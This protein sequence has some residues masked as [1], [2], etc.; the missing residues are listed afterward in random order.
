MLSGIESRLF[1]VEREWV[2]CGTPPVTLAPSAL[3]AAVVI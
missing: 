2:I 3:T 1:T